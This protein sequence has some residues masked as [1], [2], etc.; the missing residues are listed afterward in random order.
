M[1]EKCRDVGLAPGPDN[2]M[3]VISGCDFIEEGNY[4]KDGKMFQV[5]KC[6]KCGHK[7]EAWN[8]ITYD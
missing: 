1:T 3:A 4:I 5:L 8:Y 6:E 2:Q 7:S